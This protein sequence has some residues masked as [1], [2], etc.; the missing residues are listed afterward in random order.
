MKYAIEKHV[1]TEYIVTGQREGDPLK[2]PIAKCN[3]MGIAL[4]IKGMYE[5]DEQ[6]DIDI[7][8]EAARP[9]GEE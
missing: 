4:T 1:T 6:V 9:E 8:E 5:K 2:T 7:C 3:T